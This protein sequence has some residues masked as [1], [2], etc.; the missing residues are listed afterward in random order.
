MTVCTEGEGGPRVRA[1][2]QRGGSD[3][4]LSPLV[5]GRGRGETALHG[6]GR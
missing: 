3:P 5:G 4:S 1:P 6:G 2:W